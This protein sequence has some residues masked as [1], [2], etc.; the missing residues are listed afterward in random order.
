MASAA[1]LPQAPIRP[2]TTK[3][4]MAIAGEVDDDLSCDIGE[5]RGLWADAFPPIVA[6]TWQ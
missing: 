4:E 1:T 2:I 3:I 6:Y 5:V